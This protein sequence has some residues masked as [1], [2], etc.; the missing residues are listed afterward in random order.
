MAAAPTMPTTTLAY[1][2]ISTVEAPAATHNRSDTSIQTLDY[3]L[4]RLVSRLIIFFIQFFYA[5]NKI[6]VT[7]KV[8][9]VIK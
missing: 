2:Y 5:N 4:V 3:Y 8:S 7:I 1:V 9:L 6:N